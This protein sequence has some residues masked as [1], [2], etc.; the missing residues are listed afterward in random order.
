MKRYMPYVYAILAV[1]LAVLL[2]FALVPLIGYGIP[3]IMLFPVTVG[4]ALLAGLAPAVVTGLL[5]SIITDYFFIPPFYSITLDIPHVTRTAVMVF[6]S[7]FV[8]YV[9][10]VLRGARAKAEKQ[11]RAL[12]ESEAR[13]NRSQ[14][15][16]H[17]GSWELDLVSNALTWSDEVYRIFGLKPQEFGATYEAFLEAVH[18]DD[19]A[20]VN[21]AY[22]DSLR[23]GRD[24]YEIE[25]RVVRKATGEV[26]IVHEKCEH[27]RDGMGTII[28]SVGMVHDITERKRSAEALVR[29][30]EEWERTFDSVP[31]LIA[32][33][34]DQH[35]ILRVN[36]AMAQRL[37]LDADKCIGLPC[38]QYVHG[39]TGPPEFCPHLRTLK[40]GCYHAA[41][42]HEDRLGGDFLVTTNPLFDGQGR[43]IGS[44]HVAH[45][46][47]ERKKAEDEIKKLNEDLKHHVAQLEASNRELEAFSY[48]VSHDLR[49]PL[50]SIAGFC[51]ALM[52]DYAGKLE[53]DGRDALNRVNAATLRMGQLIDDLLKLSRVSR[54]EMNREPVDLSALALNIAGRLEKSQPE[55]K[56]GFVIAEGV[57]AS[58]DERLLTVVMENL[59]NNAWKFTEKRA[60]ANI[61]FGVE[62]RGPEMIYFVADNGAGFDKAYAGKLF[63]PFQRLH[64][65]ADF[66]GTGIGLATV[67]RIVERHGGR[68]WIEGEVNKGATVFFSL[69]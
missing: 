22:G 45:D 61:E 26:R 20:A 31:D 49:S 60:E 58:G 64:G 29:A 12:G 35:R 9:G 19:R 68:V 3:Y 38:Y 42:V 18:P 1:P 32:I 52:E 48:S 69:H 54:V 27:V 37:G 16:A 10:D 41:E 51:Q 40:D 17:L 28:R 11:A 23:E 6:T 63:Q 53:E 66:P 50:R 56:A 47:T 5:G 62:Q 25:H 59:L 67:R 33:I 46:I 57:S 14:Q 8:G 55:R 36:R 21:A 30:K 4:V 2:R 43:S 7:A 39:L 13:L 24:T 15:I 65:V 44:V 34:D